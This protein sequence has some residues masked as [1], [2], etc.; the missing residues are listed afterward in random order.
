MLRST[1]KLTINK[2]ESDFDQITIILYSAVIG[3]NKRKNLENG[4]E[5]VSVTIQTFYREND[6]L[7][8]PITYHKQFDY[9]LTIEERNDYFEKFNSEK[10]TF[11]EV[12]ENMYDYLAKDLIVKRYEGRVEASDFETF[13]P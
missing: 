4:S 3:V 9:P 11:A 5:S 13:Y 2:P 12:E 10:L 1:K 7:K 6:D 8:N